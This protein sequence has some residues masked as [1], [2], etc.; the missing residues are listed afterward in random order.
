MGWHEAV[1]V[2]AVDGFTGSSKTAAAEEQPKAR[3]VMDPFSTS[4]ASEVMLSIGAAVG[5]SKK[6]GHRDLAN[7]PLYRARKTLHT[8][9]GLLTTRAPDLVSGQN[10]QDALAEKVPASVQSPLSSRSPPRETLKKSARAILVFLGHPNTRNGPVE[11]LNGR[12]EHIRGS[13]GGFRNL[14]TTSM[15]IT[16]NRQIQTPTTLRIVKSL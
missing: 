5:S 16:R 4:C 13:A 2:V 6:R 12:C 10:R 3:A 15:I 11:A 8:G 14:A 7:E 9:Q 1:D